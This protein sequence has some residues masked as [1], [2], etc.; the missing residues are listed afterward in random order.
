MHNFL[1]FGDATV[2]LNDR[3]YCVVRGINNC[4]KD[5]A[6]SNGSGKSSIW[7]AISYAL[8]GETIQGLKT[9]IVNINGDDGCFVK[10]VFTVDN[11]TYEITRYK[12]YSTIGT[13][14]KVIINGEDKSGK[15]I[16]ESEQLLAQYLPD[17]TSE[18][19]G[20]VIIL[21]Q[22][23]PHKFSSYSPSGRKEL[24]E[25]LSKSD[26]MIE[27]IKNRIA[28]RSEK[29]SSDVR[30]NDDELL[31]NESKLGVYQEQL[32]E[33]ETALTEARQ[34]KNFDSTIAELNT[35]IGDATTIYNNLTTDINNLE[36]E[37]NNLTTQSIELSNERTKELEAINE[38]F[39]KE[40]TNLVNAKATLSAEITTLTN[41]INRLKSITD[42]CPTCGQ[43]IPGAIKPDTTEQEN[44]L[45]YKQGILADITTKLEKVINEQKEKQNA[46]ITHFNNKNAE[47]TTKLTELK[48]TKTN[49]TTLR[50]T[51]ETLLN[52]YKGQLQKTLL[53]KE[54]HL[55]NIKT[56]ESKKQATESEINGLNDKIV[57]NRKCGD[58][59]SEHTAVLSKISSLVKRD[60]RGF[61]LSNV[62]SFINI[63]AK[64]YCKDVFGTDE[65]EFSL[66]GNNID[67]VYCKKSI[68]N[69]SGGEKQR[70]DLILQFAIRD[71]MSQ[72]LDFSA[73]ILVL[74]EIFDNLDIIG[75][76]NVLNLISNKLN[77][78][79]SIFI[80]SHHDS[81]EIPYDDE[82]TV[83]KNE[84]GISRVK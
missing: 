50:T 79:E 27:D 10:L 51:Q 62:I 73:N 48:N 57:Y 74:D 68:E 72:Y 3:G 5:S 53:E 75:T 2:Q 60:F 8:T 56:L 49:K 61:L 11:D 80:I 44:T 76:T 30:K 58:T 18:L 45:K 41:E 67:I 38:P 28:L 77:D 55:N 19:I 43:K 40:K 4:P 83:I 64:E 21:G 71:M 34:P 17:L 22:G 81:L 70:V 33:I 26:F 46:L 59:L 6:L 13:N 32:T 52:Q 39:E 31:A 24:L 69:L 37:I 47:L 78:I 82:I 7:S 54:N 16:R 42:V 36:T 15:G 63:K 65:F 35:V 14:L 12:D 66:N 29:L 1:S 9:N 20:S 25:Q 23:L 84:R